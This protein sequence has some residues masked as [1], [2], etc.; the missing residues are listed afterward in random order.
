MPLVED[1]SKFADD[2]VVVDGAHAESPLKR[3]RPFTKWPVASFPTITHLKS[4]AILIRGRFPTSDGAK[5]SDPYPT[6]KM[7]F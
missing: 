3:S 2:H 4:L 5:D 1:A 7:K 6:C